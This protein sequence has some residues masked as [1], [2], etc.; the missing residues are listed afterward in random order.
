MRQNDFLYIAEIQGLW[1][2]K[3]LTGLTAAGRRSIIAIYKLVETD[4]VGKTAYI[5]NF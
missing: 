4:V 3:P 2:I 5:S 1:I